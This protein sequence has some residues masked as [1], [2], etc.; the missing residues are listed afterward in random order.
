MVQKS[1][2]RLFIVGV[3][4]VASLAIAV[5]VPLF[6]APGIILLLTGCYLIVW[7]TLGKGCWCR[8]C[9]KFGTF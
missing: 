2:F 4:M 8:T 7:A 9:K 3:L 5:F 6:W 1:R